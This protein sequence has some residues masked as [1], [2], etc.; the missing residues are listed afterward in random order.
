MPYSHCLHD[1]VKNG[2]AEIVKLLIK[3]KTYLNQKDPDNSWS[4]LH[5]SCYEN[6]EHVACI[7]LSKGSN[8]NIRSYY[9]QTPLHFASYFGYTNFIRL[10]LEHG[11]DPNVK[12]IEDCTPLIYATEKG[13][14]EA[15]R[16]LVECGA[17]INDYENLTGYIPIHFAV[18]SGHKRI[19]KLLIKN[20]ASH[21]LKAFD[22]STALIN[23]I[24]HLK[25]EILLENGV[26]VNSS[27]NQLVTPL[28][29]AV[30]Q[31]LAE[32][33]ILL[34]QNGAS[35]NAKD[36]YKRTPIEYSLIRKQMAVFK[37]MMAYRV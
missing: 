11:A 36:Q 31:D 12:D 24:T 18:F 34:L 20:G 16:L 33:I 10:L 37:I 6:H 22:G 35:L 32:Y 26:N 29:Y 3:E 17:N 27:C 5:L 9:L 25:V 14:Y 30:N 19:L 23:A 15:V 4:V 8:P 2:N 28:H 7:L 21:D 1:A 13:H